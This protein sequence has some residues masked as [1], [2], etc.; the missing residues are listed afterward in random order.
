MRRLG[1]GHDLGG[2]HDEHAVP[3]KTQPTIATKDSLAAVTPR[4]AQAVG[5]FLSNS[6]RGTY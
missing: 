2:G 5:E 3:S 4:R 1:P 6:A